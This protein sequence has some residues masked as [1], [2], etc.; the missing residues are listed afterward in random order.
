MGDTEDVR[1]PPDDQDVRTRRAL[2]RFVLASVVVAI[3]VG[4]VGAEAGRRAA[5]IESI[6]NARN[7]T[8]TLAHA[9]VEP[10]LGDGLYT[11]SADAIARLDSVI[12]GRV[13]DGVLVRVKIW[14]PEGRIVY[15]DEHALIGSAYPLGEDEKDAL[16]TGQVD[17]GLSDLS[18]PENRFERGQGRML[19]VYLPIHNQDGRPLLFETYSRYHEVVTA[20]AGSVWRT[21]LP[22]TLGALLV[23]QL[24]QLPL[25]WGMT[26]R[27]EHGVQE[28]ERLTREAAEASAT[29]R[30]RIAADLHDSVVQDLAAVSYSLSARGRPAIDVSA[31]AIVRRSIQSLRTLLVEIYPDSLESSGLSAA[32]SDLAAPL[33]GHG[34]DVRIAVPN[35]LDLQRQDTELLHRVAAEALRNVDAHAEARQVDVMVKQHE[36]L[37]ELRIADDGRGIDLSRKVEKGH[38]GLTLLHDRATRAGATLTVQPR[39]DA[40]GTELRLLLPCRSGVP[41]GDR[42]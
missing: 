9:V 12:P 18:A 11:G 33:R 7:L 25:V 34:V 16:A 40:A 32:L 24:L 23:L 14:T 1:S 10:Q 28:R 27:L 37:L 13:T 4:A 17:A 2:L 20:P 19:E 30:R 21:F 38:L 8:E 36:G 15:S 6:H 5:R 41:A 22:I 39:S 3:A 42:G 35:E 31:A 26:R 29:E